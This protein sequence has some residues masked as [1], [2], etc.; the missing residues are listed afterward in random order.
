MT[1]EEIYKAIADKYGID[2]M[3][4]VWLEELHELSAVI[5]QSMRDEGTREE[6]F[7]ITDF[8][9]EI[10]DVEICIDQMKHTLLSH[11]Y[12]NYADMR[13]REKINGLPKKLKL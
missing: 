13:K 5:L 12:Y 6:S 10:V 4:L 7:N 8:I 1:N 3:K 2:K 11:D 9:E